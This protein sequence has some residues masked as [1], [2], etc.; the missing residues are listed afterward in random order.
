MTDYE[1]YVLSTS[2]AQSSAMIQ[3]HF[4]HTK[5]EI[6]KPKIKLNFRILYSTLTHI[7]ILCISV[8]KKLYRNSQVRSG[9]ARI[10]SDEFGGW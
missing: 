4:I 7:Y 2:P 10:H 3:L 5:C 1:R 8:E 6:P 9:I